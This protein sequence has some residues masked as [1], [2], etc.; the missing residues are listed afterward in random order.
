MRTGPTHWL[1]GRL[2][3]LAAAGVLC[4]CGDTDGRKLERHPDRI[5]SPLVH[6]SQEAVLPPGHPPIGLSVPGLPPGHPVLPAGHPPIPAPP[7]DCPFSPADR[8]PESPDVGPDLVPGNASAP[9]V[10][11]T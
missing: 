1:G 9:V 5:D 6:A 7:L 11:R 10:L 4:A 3:A 2:T 8:A